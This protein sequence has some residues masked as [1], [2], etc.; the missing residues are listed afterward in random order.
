MKLD[1]LN[2]LE[3]TYEEF[4]IQE[5]EILDSL[6]R[7]REAAEE[8]IDYLSE[9]DGSVNAWITLLSEYEDV[10]S[11]EEYRK[12]ASKAVECI[13]ENILKL[14]LDAGEGGE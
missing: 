11:K 4:T 2:L 1:E 3:M 10:L 6:P 7:T 14:E 8:I 13:D 5:M 9:M 12:F